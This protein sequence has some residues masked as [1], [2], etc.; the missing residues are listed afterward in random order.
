MLIGLSLIKGFQQGVK[1]KFY[2]SWGHIHITPYLADPNHYLQEEKVPLNDSLLQ[3]IEAYPNVKN[4]QPFALQSVILKSKEEMEGIVFKTIFNS[5]EE[6]IK[7]VEGQ[8]INLTDSNYSED[9]LISTSLSQR[10]KVR[11]GDKILLYFLVPQNPNPIVRRGN[12]A[13]IYETGLQEFDNQIAYCDQRLIS[14]I[15]D[16]SV[17]MI[18]GYEINVENTAKIQET[19]DDIYRDLIE[20]PLYAYTLRERF[21]NIFSWLGMMKTNEQLIISIMIIVAIMNMISTMLILILERTQ[22]I[23]ILKSLGMTSGA[24]SRIFYVSGLRIIGWGLLFGNIVGLLLIFLQRQFGFVTLDPEVYYV[25]TAPAIYAWQSFIFINALMIAVML[26]IL[27]IP[28][29]LVRS[30][31]PIKALQFN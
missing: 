14:N 25:R 30:I 21:E 12:L 9:I 19:K 26:L 3:A 17:T 22:M 16:D 28:T 15:I 18:Q 24:M 27:F 8:Q 4:V 23:G 1:S 10:L 11:V 6:Q 7:L 13:G 5:K 31:K 20:A 29:I 2:S